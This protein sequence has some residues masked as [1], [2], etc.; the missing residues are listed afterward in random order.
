M[1]PFRRRTWGW[2]ALAVALVAVVVPTVLFVGPVD[3]FSDFYVSPTVA[4]SGD[5]NVTVSATLMGLSGPIGGAPIQFVTYPVPGAAAV[6]IQTSRTGSHGVATIHFIPRSPVTL[7]LFAR[8]FVPGTS[9]VV[10][11]PPA[12]IQI[13]LPPT[14]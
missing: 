7:R 5:I 11:S 3:W 4:Y 14:I 2:I 8:Y 1:P 12:V 6:I 9:D 13:Y 10:T